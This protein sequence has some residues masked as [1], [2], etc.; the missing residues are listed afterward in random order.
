MKYVAQRIDSSNKYPE[1]LKLFLSFR[2]AVAA[3]LLATIA[4]AHAERIASRKKPAASDLP[5]PP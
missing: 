2:I 3:L 4:P 1:K 5:P